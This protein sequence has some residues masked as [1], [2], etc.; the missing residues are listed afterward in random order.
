MGVGRSSRMRSPIAR[1]M[2]PPHAMNTAACRSRF[3]RGHNT[4]AASSAAPTMNSASH[5]GRSS[6]GSTGGNTAPRNMR[7]EYGTGQYRV[8]H[9]GDDIW[10]GMASYDFGVMA[11]EPAISLVSS[12]TSTSPPAA[13]ISS[14]FANT[15][16]TTFA[17]FPCTF[18]RASISAAT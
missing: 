9:A 3:D 8:I 6:A 15:A 17:R 11:S 12:A 1:E 13:R 10:G 16:V 14:T 4:I 7:I 2:H 18:T 5:P